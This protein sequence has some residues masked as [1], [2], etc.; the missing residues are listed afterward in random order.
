MNV[1]SGTNTQE[2]S[3][4][5]ILHSIL[6]YNLIIRE[7]NSIKANTL[8]KVSPL[9]LLDII[10][11]VSKHFMRCLIGVIIIQ[12]H[13]YTIHPINHSLTD[14]PLLPVYPITHTYI[15]GLV[16]VGLLRL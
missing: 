12:T 10:T 11:R 4:Y 3:V 13:K 9:L 2:Y 6:S 15:G 16:V 7:A 14:H 5:T 1:N 8:T